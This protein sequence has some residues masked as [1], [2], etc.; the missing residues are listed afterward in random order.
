MITIK[1]LTGFNAVTADE[2]FFINGG[3][4]SSSKK[5]VTPKSDS[6]PKKLVIRPIAK[7]YIPPPSDTIRPGV[8]NTAER[9]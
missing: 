2:L 1:S 5:T 8:S 9:A 4:G 7:P 6:A 3:Y